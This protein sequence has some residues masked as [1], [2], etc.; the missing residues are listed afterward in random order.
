[1][2]TGEMVYGFSL[3]AVEMVI[4]PGIAAAVRAELPGL[5]LWSDFYGFST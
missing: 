5:L 3:N 4:P 1:M 2:G